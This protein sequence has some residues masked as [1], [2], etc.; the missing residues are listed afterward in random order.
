[1]THHIKGFKG[2]HPTKCGPTPD[3]K[4]NI[5]ETI[6][7]DKIFNKMNLTIGDDVRVLEN[8]NKFDKGNTQFSKEIYEIHDRV[9]YSYKVKDTEGI[10]KR[11]RYK[12]HE[13]L[14]VDIVTSSMNT[15]RMKRDEK[16]ANKYKT[17]NKRIRNENM[18]R[19]EVKKALKGME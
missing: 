18:T 3:E 9:V 8:K 19:E 14:V 1:M 2:R 17:V 12:S 7:N 6:S 16:G 5:L 10:V 15:D 11:R 13:L 4:R